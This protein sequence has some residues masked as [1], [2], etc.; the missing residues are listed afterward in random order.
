[1]QKLARAG[2]V[3]CGAFVWHACA[4]GTD[5]TDSLT[6]SGPANLTTQIPSCPVGVYYTPLTTTQIQI[7]SRRTQRAVANFVTNINAVQ[8]QAGL[9]DSTSV[10]IQILEAEVQNVFSLIGTNVTGQIQPLMQIGDVISLGNPFGGATDSPSTDQVYT[11]AW[12]ALALVPGANINVTLSAT[13]GGNP[14]VFADGQI[15]TFYHNGTNGRLIRFPAGGALLGLSQDYILANKGDYLQLRYNLAANLWEMYYFS[16]SQRMSASAP[17]T[18]N[19]STY[20]VGV[21]DTALR[22]TTTNCTVTLPSAAFFPG[23]LLNVQTLTGNSLVS[24]SSNVCPLGSSTPGT[25]IL[26]ASSGKFANLRSDGTNWDIE[27]SN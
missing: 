14:Y 4:C 12:A 13:F 20:T 27:G 16:S 7:R 17:V 25:A 19:A 1:M 10:R 2:L 18:V 23:R 21:N 8:F 26:A 22:I 6:L 11:P 9:I 15:I 24:A 5:A 3:I